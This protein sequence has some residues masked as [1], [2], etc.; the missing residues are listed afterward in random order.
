MSE[1]VHDRDLILFFFAI[2]VLTHLPAS[3][4]VVS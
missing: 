3:A 2:I 4:S 1:L